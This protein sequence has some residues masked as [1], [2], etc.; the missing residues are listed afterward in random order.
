[1]VLVLV[2]AACSGESIDSG[3]SGVNGSPGD[4]RP[5]PRTYAGYRV[6]YPCAGTSVDV[7]VEGL[8]RIR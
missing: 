6:S 8:G 2:L 3:E 1:L 7:G 5:A 4:L